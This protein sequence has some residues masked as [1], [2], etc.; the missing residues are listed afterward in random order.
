LK[1]SSATGH[2]EANYQ[3]AISLLNETC[4]KSKTYYDHVLN[5]LNKAANAGH[6]L[7]MRKIADMNYNGEGISLN[8]LEAKHWYEMAAINGN[9]SSQTLYAKML[10]QKACDSDDSYIQASHYFHLAADQGDPIAQNSLGVLYRDGNGVEQDDNLSYKY[11]NRSA[12]LGLAEG[13]NNLGI[14][15]EQGFLSN[16]KRIGI[17]QNLDE[18]IFWYRKAASQSFSPSLNNLGMLYENGLGVDQGV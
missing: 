12:A 1:K 16:N 14:C 7:S 2:P 8:I 17:A 11:F 5:I 3:Y 6:V 9:S 10:L 15:Y 18:A 4:S 13:Q